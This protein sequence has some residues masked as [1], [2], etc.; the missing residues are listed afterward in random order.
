MTKQEDDKIEAVE[1]DNKLHY[2]GLK[3]NYKVVLK[4]ITINGLLCMDI[5]IVSQRNIILMRERLAILCQTGLS[6]I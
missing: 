1:A 2:R 4:I 3:V 6:V 5:L